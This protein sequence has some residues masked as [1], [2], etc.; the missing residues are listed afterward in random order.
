MRR[1]APFSL[2]RPALAAVLLT[3]AAC[4]D[5]N[6]AAPSESPAAPPPGG[7]AAAV[8]RCTVE[9][10]AATVACRPL[11]A[12]TASG[13]RAA[14]LG[15]QGSNVRV[16]S[17]GTGYDAQTQVFR[18]AVTVQNLTAQ[19]LAIV[20]DSAAPEGVRVFFHSGPDVTS[21]SGSV[22]VANADGE[23]AFTAAVQKYFQY[24]GVLAPGAT[25]APKEWR[26]SVPS[27]VL[28]FA[29]TL[30]VAAPVRAE[31]GWVGVR[32]LAPSLLVGDTQRVTA[33]VRAVTGRELPGEPVRWWSS[34]PGVARV[35]SLGLVTAVGQGTAF[36][37]AT[38][39]GRSG[40]AEVQV[41]TTFSPMPPSVVGFELDR[42][43]ITASDADSLTV[44]V[45]AKAGGAGPETISILLMEPNGNHQYGCDASTLVG[46]TVN[47]GVWQCKIAIEPYTRRGI[48]RVHS[49]A[50]RAWSSATRTVTTST[51]VGAGAPSYVRVEN[52]YDVT[53]PVLHGLT[54]S[55]ASVNLPEKETGVE[56]VANALVSDAGE[57]D[58]VTITFRH[59]SSTFPLLCTTYQPH[60]GGDATNGTFRCAMAVYGTLASGDWTMDEVRIVD[61]VGNLT[62][63]K[64]ADL[65]A[66]GYPTKLTLNSPKADLVPPALTA[67][68]YGAA[69]SGNTANPL[70]VTLTADGGETGVLR[71]EALFQKVGGTQ[72]RKCTA[73]G[74]N[75]NV[76]VSVTCQFR[77][78]AGEVGLWRVQR[79]YALD[80]GNARTFTTAELAAAGFRTEFTVTAAP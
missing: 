35:D 50:A 1:R 22:A 8:L 13:A 21:G 54:L 69:V 68:S 23:A 53:A 14:I 55:P 72:T 28:T 60:A 30:Y 41:L 78:D 42:T 51:L 63:L 24:D 64:T 40:R 61:V 66:A 12:E 67:F 31:A 39:G 58:R 46:G 38:S 74:F 32:P 11:D 59:P 37:T 80:E 10:R 62:V 7:P 45:A 48:W 27:T 44:R 34:N 17:S 9:V 71:L 76:T 5:R 77:F 73:P 6:P 20:G 36:I 70:F 49:V 56:V 19:P 29:F 25:T 15:G 2:V 3:V 52:G 4:A 79:V 43:A 57:V 18:T 16:A 47:D 26:F 65:V 75:V 33:A